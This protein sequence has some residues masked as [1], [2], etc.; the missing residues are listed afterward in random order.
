MTDVYCN[1]DECINNSDGC[2]K[3]PI[4]EYHKGRCQSYTTARDLMCTPR[5][6]VVKT[7]RYKQIRGEVIR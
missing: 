7:R 2:C 6:K 1:S 5:A 3:A 4:V